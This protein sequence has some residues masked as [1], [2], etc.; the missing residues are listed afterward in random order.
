[1]RLQ[2]SMGL[3]VFSGA[4]LTSNRP[5]TLSPTQPEE[6]EEEELFPPPPVQEEEGADEDD[7]RAVISNPGSYCKQ[8]NPQRRFVNCVFFVQYSSFVLIQ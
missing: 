4:T 8:K 7:I 5:T 1:M 6:E 3:V 2:L